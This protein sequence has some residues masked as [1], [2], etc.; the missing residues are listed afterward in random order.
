M[1]IVKIH[2]GNNIHY[3]IARRYTY[4]VFLIMRQFDYFHA[5]KN[6]IQGIYSTLPKKN[7]FFLAEN[8][9]Q[10]RG[11]IKIIRL[12]IEKPLRLI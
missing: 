2:F 11:Q 4:I 6:F 1:T 8:F 9:L 7:T 12:V 3:F 10:L 5:N